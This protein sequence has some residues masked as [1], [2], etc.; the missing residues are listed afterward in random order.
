MV[1][2]LSDATHDFISRVSG[3]RRAGAFLSAGS[4]VVV[5]GYHYVCDQPIGL[6]LLSGAAY[7]CAVYRSDV[8]G[9]GLMLVKQCALNGG[10]TTRYNEQMSRRSERTEKWA[11]K[12]TGTL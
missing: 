6:S 3:Y 1:V 9:C 11:S 4:T 10:R 7:G 5:A 12:V 2:V 8:R